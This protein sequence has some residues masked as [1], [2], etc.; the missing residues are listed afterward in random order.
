MA[1]AISGRP[2]TTR[3]RSANAL[4]RLRPLRAIRPPDV[5]RAIEGLGE[6]HRAQDAKAPAVHLTSGLEQDV[7]GQ[8][9]IRRQKSDVLVA[10]AACQAVP[11]KPVADLSLAFPVIR[12]QWREFRQP[13]ARERIS[14]ASAAT[15]HCG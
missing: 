13:R 6:D 7:E 12:Q 1:G 9:R 5:K 14:A 8:R 10:Q 15:D 2:S 11:A 3:A 4:G